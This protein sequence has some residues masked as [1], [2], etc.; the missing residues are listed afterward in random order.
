[1]ISIIFVLIFLRTTK[2]KNPLGSDLISSGKLEDELQIKVE[3]SQ[4]FTEQNVE[5]LLNIDS[6]ELFTI[7]CESV[8][9][10]DN[11]GHKAATS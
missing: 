9:P 11:V 3:K 7:V 1:M 10:H 2:T 5:E 6:N 8:P 4:S